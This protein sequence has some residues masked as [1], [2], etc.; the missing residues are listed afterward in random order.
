M[1]RTPPFESSSQA[2][3]VLQQ[4]AQLTSKSFHFSQVSAQRKTIALNS[5][6]CRKSHLPIRI[7]ETKMHQLKL[8]VLWQPIH[9]FLGNLAS[10]LRSHSYLLAGLKEWNVAPQNIF[11][12]FPLGKILQNEK[13]TLPY[14]RRVPFELVRDEF[15]FNWC[16]TGV[17]SQIFRF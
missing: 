16:K 11:T 10:D 5:V 6:Q 1:Q 8:P 7:L 2:S 17:E 4:F 3:S 15:L 13:G 14:H 12:N 9:L